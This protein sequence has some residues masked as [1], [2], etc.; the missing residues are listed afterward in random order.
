MKS[1]ILTLNTKDFLRGLVIAAGTGAGVVLIPVLTAGNLPNIGHLKLAGTAAICAG[2]TYLFKNLF[3]NSNDQFGK[4]ETQRKI[5]VG[6]I[7]GH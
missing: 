6:S 4:G 3:T 7:E 1:K 5:N 2:G